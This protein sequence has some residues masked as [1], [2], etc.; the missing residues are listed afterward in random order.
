MLVTSIFS[1]CRKRINEKFHHLSNNQIIVYKC[2]Q[3]L[4]KA[5]LLF[6]GKGL[7]PL[8]LISQSARCNYS[9]SCIFSDDV[10]WIC[11]LCAKGFSNQTDL[12]AHQEKC[13]DSKDVDD[14]ANG[15]AVSSGKSDC[16]QCKET[17]D[18]KTKPNHGESVEPSFL[19][20]VGSDRKSLPLNFSN[21][22]R[23]CPSRKRKRNMEVYIP[24][25][26][27]IY[28]ESL[29]LVPTPK[30]DL[31]KTP[32]K[33]PS[34]DCQI[35]DLT[36]DEDKSPQSQPMT[37]RTHLIMAQLSREDCS[38]GRRRQLSFSQSSPPKLPK[39]VES[40]SESSDSS[41]EEPTRKKNVPC[42]S[43]ILA[44]PL[45]SLLGQRLKKHWQSDN[46]IPVISDVESFCQ[47]SNVQ[48]DSVSEELERKSK[49]TEKL[50]HRPPPQ[51]TFRYTKKYINKWFHKYKFN[52]ADKEEFKH[53][54]ATGLE[55][56]SRKILRRM[57]KCK[58]SL[59]RIGKKEIRYWTSSRPKLLHSQSIQPMRQNQF[60][61]LRMRL[62]NPGPRGI[63]PL[64]L[65]NSS[66]IQI[67]QRRERFPVPVPLFAQTQKLGVPI[68]QFLVRNVPAGE[69]K[70]R[71]EIMPVVQRTFVPV[72]KNSL[73]VKT[74]QRKKAF[75]KPPVN[76][77]SV[78]CLS[79]DEE[80]NIETFPSCSKCQSP[81]T[82]CVCSGKGRPK[83]GP[84]S[85]MKHQR[86]LQ[87]RAQMLRKSTNSNRNSP[88]V[89]HTG[90]ADS[91][92]ARLFGKNPGKGSVDPSL[93]EQ[94]SRPNMTF[95]QVKKESVGTTVCSKAA[96]DI[97]ILD[98]KSDS[99][100]SSSQTR[101]SRF[102]H[103]RMVNGKIVSQVTG[104][105]SPTGSQD[106]TTEHQPG[107][108]VKQ[109]NEQALSDA[110][111]MDFEVICIDSDEET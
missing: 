56:E 75:H 89:V 25:P 41:I 21:I 35:V 12:M 28:F 36:L 26:R 23:K 111:Y 71:M 32:Q 82:A 22:N 8:L 15:S 65:L 10:V 40:D 46:K 86:S 31:I 110:E 43:V 18:I 107:S 24:P 103:I 19:T 67:G 42:K 13:E 9:S 97:Q 60:E 48:Y 73:V 96:N 61:Q 85:F 92:S 93:S 87:Q 58:V 77:N 99:S 84:A 2:F 62:S 4:V 20:K 54:L 38:G 98:I 7:N 6:S 30:V 47:T 27:E 1:F 95:T 55:Y 70:V 104:N 78:I 74:E 33:N 81:R 49:F 108:L 105:S 34:Q 37:P 52:K 53:N 79:S 59:E 72:S 29:G 90:K 3:A 88:P 11:F 66:I 80:D 57:K 16:D 69:N 45:T 100:V 5:K 44:I 102:T 17:M 68:P 76:S 94:G 83:I 51:L 39:K 101:E 14:S 50:R 91:V 109:E 63:R 106:S 64:Q